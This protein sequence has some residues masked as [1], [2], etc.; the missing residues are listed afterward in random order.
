MYF[1]S[2]VIKMIVEIALLFCEIVAVIFVRT[3]NCDLEVAVNVLLLSEGL[4]LL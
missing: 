2:Y 4:V 3:T 1:F